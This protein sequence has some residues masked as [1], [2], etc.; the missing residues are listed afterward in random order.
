[1][2]GKIW[3]FV[4]QIFNPN[5]AHIWQKQKFKEPIGPSRDSKISQKTSKVVPSREYLKALRFY[6]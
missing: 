1:M 6:S 5:W 2:K 4:V 3:N